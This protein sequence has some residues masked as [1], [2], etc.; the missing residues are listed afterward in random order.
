MDSSE[1]EVLQID[2]VEDLEKDCDFVFVKFE[3]KKS[4]LHNVGRVEEIERDGDLVVNFL[5]RKGASREFTFPEVEDISS[6]PVTDVVL[7]M[8][9][10]MQSGG[11]LRTKSLYSFG[12]RFE[13]SADVR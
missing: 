5:R 12:F 4:K 2:D 11:T 1:D 13:T 3:G 7:K 10:S 9:P 8:P 6:V